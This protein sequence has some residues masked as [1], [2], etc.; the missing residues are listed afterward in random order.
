MK[1]HID[2]KH[3]HE[4]HVDEKDNEGYN[5][6]IDNLAE[7]AAE[8][9]KAAFPEKFQ[10]YDTLGDEFKKE[11]HHNIDDFMQHFRQGYNAILTEA[12]RRHGRDSDYCKKIIPKS[13]KKNDLK[14]TNKN[15]NAILGFSDESLTVMYD[16]ARALLEDKQ[17]QDASDAFFFLSSLSPGTSTFWLG[18]ARSERM[19]QRQNVALGAYQMSLIFNGEEPEHYLEAASCCIEMHDLDM[20]EEFLCQAESYA[21]EHPRADTATLLREY[22]TQGKAELKQLKLQAR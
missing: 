18:Y 15:L 21:E 6:A 7:L 14:H 4:K 20:A 2:E 13:H 10:K 22:A 19:N 9:L 3:I 16:T 5:E 12:I 11:L 17:T 8:N 1:K